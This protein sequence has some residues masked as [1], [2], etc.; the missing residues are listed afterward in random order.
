MKLRSTLLGLSIAF[1]L[2]AVSCSSITEQRAASQNAKLQTVTQPQAVE[3]IDA[4]AGRIRN[5]SEDSKGGVFI[6]PN[7]TKAAVEAP[8][9]AH[10]KINAGQSHFTA[11][12]SAGGL[13]SA[14][15]HDHMISMRDLAGDVQLT[16][17]T[18]VPASL[19]MT[20]KANSAA[21]IGKGVS[22]KDR[23]LIARSVHDGALE[24]AKYPEIIFKSTQISTTKT[25]EEQYQAKITGQLTL[26]GVT[27]PVTIPAQVT[28]SGKT[29][30]ARGE[31]NIRHS[32]YKI[33]Q[34][35]ALSGTVKAKD[36]MKLLFDIVANKY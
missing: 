14:F 9:A 10:F 3:K 29:L 1:A 11:H 4:P 32:D 34:L 16:P 17:D 12:V 31:F 6:A 2:G 5:T 28:L 23:Q 33:K 20:I 7:V 21:E 18:I 36:E 19:R 30:R 27:L 8:A 35:S 25:G 15:G 26:H 24:A 13:L 22:E